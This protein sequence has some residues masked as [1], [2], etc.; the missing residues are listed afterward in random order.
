MTMTTKSSRRVKP[1]PLRQRCRIFVM[2]P[3]NCRLFVGR[4]NSNAGIMTLRSIET[5]HL[6]VSNASGLQAIPTRDGPHSE[7]P[8]AAIQMLDGAADHKFD[9]TDQRRGRKC[10]P[11]CA[12]NRATRVDIGDTPQ[13]MPNQLLLGAFDQ[14]AS[15]SSSADWSCPRK[16]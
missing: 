4:R 5:T 10:S 9:A 11:S 2:P 16:V 1:L 15:L 3:S 7:R 8:P 14:L 12:V 13:T 6:S